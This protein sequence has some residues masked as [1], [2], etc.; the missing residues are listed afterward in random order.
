MD[1]AAEVSEGAGA[2]LVQFLDHLDT[3]AQASPHTRTGYAHDIGLYLGFMAAHTGGPMG[4]AALAG[5]GVADLRAWMAAE[6]RRG[7]GPASLARALSAV[8]SF[9]AWLA[10]ARGLDCPAMA[11]VR[12]PRQPRRLPRPVAAPDARA[13]IAA[14]SAERAPWIAARD[15]A[16][17][18]LLWATGLRIAEALSLRQHHAPLG[19]VLRVVGKGGRPREVP[20][21]A[22]A[23][24][25]VEAY[26]DAC[27]YRP[28]PQEALFLG[29]RGGP[30][31]ASV[32]QAAMAAARRALGL[33]ATA[34]P[35]ALRHA[36]ATHLLTAG[37]DL[38]AIQ[39][40]LGHASIGTT[41]GYLAVD[42]P[43]LARIHATSHP[44]GG[45]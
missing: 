16:A 18:T 34:T 36:F 8:R 38:R 32:L 26:R 30:L 37:G 25:A 43:R 45:D 41:A 7:L 33:P 17:L 23:R 24:A 11:V 22:V 4:A 12:S 40:L 31:N 20:V 27:P 21:V 35:H 15:A 6:R 28:G 44:R 39:T 1:R 9:H 42:A 3:V 5:V 19:E 14:V 10:T 2:L 13:L 29:A